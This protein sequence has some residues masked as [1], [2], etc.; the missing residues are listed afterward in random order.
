MD[1]KIWGPSAWKFLHCITIG[2]P[3]CPSNE[4]KQNIK[5]FFANLHTILPC[6]VCKAHFKDHFA[7]YPL[8]DEILCNKKE[9]FKWLV[10]VRNYVNMQLKKPI[11]SQEDVLKE[12]VGCSKSYVTTKNITF[13]LV[14]IVV[15]ILIV[16]FIRYKY[17]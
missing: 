11:I 13:V 2:Y 15:I 1:P 9:L 3:D 7:K 17:K 10:D 6:D 16:L 12:C 4:D 8:T 5:Q 14:G